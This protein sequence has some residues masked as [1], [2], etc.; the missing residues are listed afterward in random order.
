MA[1]EE[2][3]V[4]KTREEKNGRKADTRQLK[5]KLCSIQSLLRLAELVYEG[6]DGKPMDEEEL[7]RNKNPRHC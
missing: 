6:V 3:E 7:T 5:R 1:L 2:L 4:L